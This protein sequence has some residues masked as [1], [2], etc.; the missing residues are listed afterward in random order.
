MDQVDFG[1]KRNGTRVSVDAAA[2]S[3]SS[4]SYTVTGKL[5]ATAPCK[6]EVRRKAWARHPHHFN[7]WQL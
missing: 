6:K 3:R 2:Y 5:A 7:H 1:A 4:N